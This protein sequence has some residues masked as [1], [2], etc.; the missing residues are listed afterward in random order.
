MKNICAAFCF[1]F[2][3][4]LNGLGQQPINHKMDEEFI[5]AAK[6]NDIK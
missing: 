4:L 1:V 5:K 2:L 6:T 3:G